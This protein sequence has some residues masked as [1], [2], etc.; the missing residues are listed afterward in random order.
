MAGIV[1]YDTIIVQQG[2]CLLDIALQEYGSAE[3]VVMLMRD[4]NLSLD[5]NLLPGTALVVRNTPIN[6]AVKNYYAAKRLKVAGAVEIVPPEVVTPEIEVTELF[7]SSAKII[8][9][10]IISV[11]C[12]FTCEGGKIITNAAAFS[13]EFTQRQMNG[14]TNPITACC[15]NMNDLSKIIF[16]SGGL[17]YYTLDYGATINRW[18]PEWDYFI[19]EVVYLNGRDWFY[20]NGVPS[21][22]APHIIFRNKQDG[23]QY[24]GYLASTGST[25][26]F[27]AVTFNGGDI[28]RISWP[29]T[30]VAVTDTCLYKTSGYWSIS[31]GETPGDWSKVVWVNNNYNNNGWSAD[32]YNMAVLPNKLYVEKNYTTPPTDLTLA[33]DIYTDAYFYR[34][35]FS[36]LLGTSFYLVGKK[37]GHN[38]H[39]IRKLLPDGTFKTALMLDYELKNLRPII[40][41]KN[42]II[43]HTDYKIIKLTLK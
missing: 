4:N 38:G 26:V 23:K 17:L 35:D 40:L 34:V 21:L 39:I 37:Y 31:N 33:F 29:N 5:A 25:V 32:R 15:R 42:A 8:N 36:F 16:S 24:I 9:A 14:I 41:G 12:A 1:T 2:Q 11:H 3:G 20:N 13:E 28:K 30:G 19:G 43:G 7:T 22:M 27:Q 10:D 6:K 18:Y